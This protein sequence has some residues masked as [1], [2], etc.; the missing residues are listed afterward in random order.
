[1]VMSMV[2]YYK[3]FTPTSCW[4]CERAFYSEE[5]RSP[6]SGP[7]GHHLSPKQ[8]KHRSKY[9]L[10]IKNICKDCHLQVHKMYKNKELLKLG[11]ELLNE[12]KVKEWKKWIRKE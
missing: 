10:E 11:K 6:V 3:G 8:L 5:G 2:E 7:F 12:K 4:I 9:E 1:M